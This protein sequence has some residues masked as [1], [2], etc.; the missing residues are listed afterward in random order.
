MDVTQ[1]VGTIWDTGGTAWIAAPFQLDGDPIAEVVAG[2]GI[3]IRDR[4]DDFYGLSF[5]LNYDQWNRNLYDYLTPGDMFRLT[6]SGSN[7]ATTGDNIAYARIGFF[8]DVDYEDSLSSV[9][10]TD[11]VDGF[12]ISISFS[13]SRTT[14][15]TI[16]TN[17]QDGN[18]G[19]GPANFTIYGATLERLPPGTPGTDPGTDPGTGTVTPTP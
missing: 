8:N 2:G 4:A 15:L 14:A 1:V 17:W 3:L 9:L 11:G 12:E 10:M 18:E 5:V 7:D 19:D 16:R 13:G 6:V